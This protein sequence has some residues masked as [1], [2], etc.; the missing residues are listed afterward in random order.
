VKLQGRI[1]IAAPAQAVWDLLLDPDRLAACVPGVRDV[2]ALDDRTFTGRISAAVGPLQSDFAFRTV[3]A[4]ATFPD[5]LGVDMTGT[6][7]MTRSTL[8]TTVDIALDAP[9]PDRTVL[10]YT[11]AVTIKGRLA[12]LGEM[13]LRATA[14]AVIGEV[15]T[16]MRSQLEAS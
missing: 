9:A 10:R 8:T 6:D 16:R 7:S 1:E 13:I 3:V 15:G 5:D 2:A 11:A 14:G 12:I 4:R